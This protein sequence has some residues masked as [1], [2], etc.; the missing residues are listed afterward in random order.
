MASLHSLAQSLLIF[1][2]ILLCATVLAVLAQS[3]D[4]PCYLN[5][6]ESGHP[7]KSCKQKVLTNDHYLNHFNPQRGIYGDCLPSGVEEK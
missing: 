7:D 1:T 5:L 3:D 6:D 4:C 2:A